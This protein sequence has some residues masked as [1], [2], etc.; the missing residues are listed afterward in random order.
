M[1]A[2]AKDRPDRCASP[3]ISLAVIELVGGGA[4]IR[5]IEAARE[6]AHQ[7]SIKLFVICR[8]EPSLDLASIPFPELT[9]IPFGGETVPKRRLTALQK[10]NADL[11]GLIEDTVL[12]SD[13]WIDGVIESFDDTNT[14]AVWGPVMISTD[15]GARNRALAILEYG[16]FSAA[17]GNAGELAYAHLPGCNLVVRRKMTLAAV[18]CVEDGVFE[19]R[20]V[21]KFRSGGNKIAFNIK[22]A[23]TYNA[24]DEYGARLTTRLNHGRLYA[25]T[26]AR[27]LSQWSRV[28]HAVRGVLAPAA[29]TARGVRNA[30]RAADGAFSLQQFFWIVLMSLAWGAGEIQGYILGCGQSIKSWR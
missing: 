17:A 24:C 22:T 7:R 12:V 5:S 14:G 11:V 3:T 27:S 15:L 8:G 18:D 4:L 28:Y 30:R 29:L 26:Q 1:K 25:G 13:E 19:H 10:S 23:V 16:R 21:E 6:L 9:I 2:G 20:I